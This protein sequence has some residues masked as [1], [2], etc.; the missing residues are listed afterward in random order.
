[1]TK[2][3]TLILNQVKFMNCDCIMVFQ[4]L[5]KFQT[6][7]FNKNIYFLGYKSSQLVSF[8]F[9]IGTS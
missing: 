6:K 9:R 5:K 1:M 8:E 4:I 3:I 2:A 7:N